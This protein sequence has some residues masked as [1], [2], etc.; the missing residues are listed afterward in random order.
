MSDLIAKIKLLDDPD[1]NIYQT[2]KNSIISDGIDAIP[3]L[4][5]AW[6][7]EYNPLIQERI[8]EIIKTIQFSH[9]KKI[10]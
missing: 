7:N 5:K 1:E 2:I 10:I 6:G 9:L 3:L 8:E 4:E